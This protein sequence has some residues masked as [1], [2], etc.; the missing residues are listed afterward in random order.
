[1]TKKR[2]QSSSFDVQAIK[3]YFYFLQIIRY[4]KTFY[5]KVNF[6]KAVIVK[7]GQTCLLSNI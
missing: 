6:L 3:L 2:S 5:L 4:K 7:F 1:M